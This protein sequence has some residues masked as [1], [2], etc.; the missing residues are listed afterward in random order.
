MPQNQKL[1]L[2]RKVYALSQRELANLLNLSQSEMSRLEDGTHAP[3]LETVFCLQVLFD[4]AP[5][6]L[7][8]DLYAEAGEAVMRRASR[9]DRQLT[10]KN[11]AASLKKKRLLTAMVDRAM[12]M[13]SL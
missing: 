4:V 5:R 11:D 10:G 2:N 7:F 13:T 12:P 9:L 6:H 1:R 8:P 3:R